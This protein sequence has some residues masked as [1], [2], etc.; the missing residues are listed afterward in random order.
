M[1]QLKEKLKT[2]IADAQAWYQRL[3]TRERQMVTLGSAAAGVFFLIIMMVSFSASARG[4]RRRIE[5]KR[6]S[7]KE[8]QLLAN[9]FRDAEVQRKQVEDQLRQSAVRLTGFI[10]ERGTEVGMQIPVM[11][12][13]G[14]Q[15]LGDG[16][17]IESAIE[18]T[19]TDITLNQL[20]QFLSSIERAP[21]VVRVKFLRVVPQ[22]Q[23]ESLTAW[24]TVAAYRLKG[25]EGG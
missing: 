20:V 17:I 3:T 22:K 21:G 14:D 19:L 10:E 25:G 2:L 9:S 7:L 24:L 6:S 12:P 15:A 1:E 16:R 11:N 4:Y 23:K 8:I 13:K 18:V 5:E